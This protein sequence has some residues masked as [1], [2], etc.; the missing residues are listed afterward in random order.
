MYF[1]DPLLWVLG[2][3]Y[4]L[5]T[6]YA[7]ADIRSTGSEVLWALILYRI[8]HDVGA[9]DGPVTSIGTFSDPH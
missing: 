3:G 1:P 6:G 9:R 7:T 2:L 4:L 5:H 8:A